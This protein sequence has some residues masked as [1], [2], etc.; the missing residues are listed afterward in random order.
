MN[1][2]DIIAIA[3]GAAVLTALTTVGLQARTRWS[4]RSSFGLTFPDESPDELYRSYVATMDAEVVRYLKNEA[5]SDV[6]WIEAIK[7]RARANV[8]S[9]PEFTIDYR[10]L[11]HI[12]EIRSAYVSFRPEF[13]ASAA[14]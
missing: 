11:T 12:P 10:Q 5:L 4:R 9:I 6:Q 13:V 1:G 8:G 14:L 3:G 7:A 2:N